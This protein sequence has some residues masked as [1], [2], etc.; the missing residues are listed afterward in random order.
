MPYII[1]NVYVFGLPGC[2]VLTRFHSF[3]K[4]YVARHQLILDLIEFRRESEAL[5]SQGLIDPYQQ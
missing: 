1:R 5:Q 3:M 2:R 4:K